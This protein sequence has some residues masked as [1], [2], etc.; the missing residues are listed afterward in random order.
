MITIRSLP[1]MYC[2]YA[3]MQDHVDTLTH[4]KRDI[5]CANR[6][7]PN[8]VHGHAPFKFVGCNSPDVAELY[9]YRSIGG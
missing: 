2:S 9:R 6:A 4:Q 7:T 8:P 3:H 1:K 5:A